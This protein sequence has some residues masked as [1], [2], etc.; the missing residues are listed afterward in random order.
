MTMREKLSAAM[1]DRAE[2]P[3]RPGAASMMNQPALDDLIDAALDA[4]MDPSEGMVAATIPALTE[5]DT[6]DLD[7]FP[8][9][10]PVASALAFRAMIRAAKEGK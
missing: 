9:D 6:F 3:Q 4:L 2:H 10:I 7:A 8:E 5:P 1:K